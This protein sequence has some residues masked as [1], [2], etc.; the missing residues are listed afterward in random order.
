[1]A[2]S[3]VAGRYDKAV[4]R[5][6]AFETLEKRAKAAAQAEADA[7]SAPRK[8]PLTLDLPDVG[9][10][11][12]AAR[13][14]RARPA[15]RSVPAPR[16]GGMGASDASRGGGEPRARWIRFGWGSAGVAAAVEV[17]GARAGST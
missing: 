1:M 6:L 4:D 14:C 10:G 3:P 9:G 11:R 13:R 15:A 2:Q 8:R 16:G 12:T 7:E 17:R 5:E